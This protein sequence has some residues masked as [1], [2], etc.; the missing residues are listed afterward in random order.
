MIGKLVDIFTNTNLDSKTLSELLMCMEGNI[1]EVI[2]RIKKRSIKD[3]KDGV[4]SNATSPKRTE[5]K[6]KDDESSWKDTSEEHSSDDDRAEELFKAL[7]QPR[8]DRFRRS[9]TYHMRKENVLNHL[10]QSS[11]QSLSEEGNE[12]ESDISNPVIKIEPV[13][14]RT[15]K[16]DDVR[17]KENE[18]EAVSLVKQIV[19]PKRVSVFEGD[20]CLV[21]NRFLSDVLKIHENIRKINIDEIKLEEKTDE[22]LAAENNTINDFLGLYK[23]NKQSLKTKGRSSVVQF[24]IDNNLKKETM[25]ESQIK[26][27]ESQ[28]LPNAV[29]R[30]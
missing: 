30:M 8:D 13:S 12:S 1:W 17:L 21:Q 20:V 29:K 18:K 27:T 24:L 9:S 23:R 11:E 10:N 16:L 14:A 4:G 3:K 15:Q 25:D 6:C 28:N 22:E 26:K 5:R 19:E 7:K 2:K